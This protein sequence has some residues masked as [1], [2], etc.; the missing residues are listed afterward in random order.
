MV[1]TIYPH[2][3]ILSISSTLEYTNIYNKK[4][5]PAAASCGRAV[6]CVV[7]ISLT[8]LPHHLHHHPLHFNPPSVSLPPVSSIPATASVPTRATASIARW[9]GAPHSSRVSPSRR[10][11]PSWPRSW[12][13][14]PLGTLAKSTPSWSRTTHSLL[15]RSPKSL[16][17]PSE[18]LGRVNT[19]RWPSESSLRRINPHRHRHWHPHPTSEPTR[20]ISPHWR[21][22]PVASLW[23]AVTTGPVAAR[24]R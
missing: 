7:T 24:I 16:W 15:R 23:R 21:R 13:P 5:Y 6:L 8:S 9:R 19:W 17:W 22:A 18:P 12:A 4:G 20:R 3:L 1:D 11:K 10:P 14:S 2:N